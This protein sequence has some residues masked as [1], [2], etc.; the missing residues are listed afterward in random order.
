MVHIAVWID[1]TKDYIWYG[2]IYAPNFNHFL[3]SVVLDQIPIN[4]CTED[5]Y[6]FNLDFSHH[7]LFIY[8]VI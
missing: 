8:D 4:H 5:A 6:Y 2:Y 3:K 1:A 7:S